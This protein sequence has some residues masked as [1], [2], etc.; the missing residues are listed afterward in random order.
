MLT[1]LTISV[2]HHEGCLL[3]HPTKSSFK[4][5]I[6]HHDG[7]RLVHPANWDILTMP[8]TIMTNLEWCIMPCG[9]LHKFRFAFMMDVDWFIPP[10]SSFGILIQFKMS[11]IDQFIYNSIN[12]SHVINRQTF[13]ISHFQIHM[14]FRNI[15]SK[16]YSS[17][18]IISDLVGKQPKHLK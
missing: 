7:C 8:Y 17:H 14:H 3:V 6:R 2:S 9:T 1:H 18:I 12:H 10:H 13:Q 11:R 4:N 5:S 15:I 16:I